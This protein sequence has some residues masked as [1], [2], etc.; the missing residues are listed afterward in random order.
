MTDTLTMHELSEE[1][2]AFLAALENCGGRLDVESEVALADLGDDLDRY[3][4]ELALAC[5]ELS[6]TA[7]ALEAE[8][9]RIAAKFAS[10]VIPKRKAIETIRRLMA[11]HMA[12]EDL[13]RV[14]TDLVTVSLVKDPVRYDW[15]GREDTIPEDFR[16]TLTEHRVNQDAVRRHVDEGLPLPEGIVP[17]ESRHI[18]IL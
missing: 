15:Q 18:R 16:T 12:K 4:P 7:V 11:D 13:T 3:L 9:D 2:R 10:R 8:R 14:R 5:R 6:G 1:V 17:R